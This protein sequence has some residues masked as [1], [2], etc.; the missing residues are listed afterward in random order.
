MVDS[1]LELAFVF[2]GTAPEEGELY[3]QIEAPIV[4]FYGGDDE[5]VNATIPQTEAYMQ[6]FEQTYQYEIYTGAG[7]AFMRR[8]VQP[9]AEVANVQ[10]REQAFDRMLSEL[11]SLK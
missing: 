4:A 11:A 6:Q 5:R 7:H 10:A 9:D 8:A 2:Y 1:G 3:E